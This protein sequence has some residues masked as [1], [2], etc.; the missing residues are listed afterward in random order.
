MAPRWHQIGPKMAQNHSKNCGKWCSC[1]S[2]TFIFT[3]MQYRRVKTL[4]FG[5]MASRKSPRPPAVAITTPTVVVTTLAV[6]VST[7]ARRFLPLLPLSPARAARCPGPA[8]GQGGQG[9]QIPA[10]NLGL[11]WPEE[12]A[13]LLAG[14]KLE[15]GLSKIA[16]LTTFVKTFWVTF[17]GPF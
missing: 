13:V 12:A 1:R 4:A 8:P 3:K 14:R 9:G 11:A 7:A 2:E 6:V 17:P 16:F 15:D 10:T 5:K